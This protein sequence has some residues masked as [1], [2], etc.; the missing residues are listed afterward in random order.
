MIIKSI[1][2]HNFCDVYYNKSF[3]TFKYIGIILLFHYK[4]SIKLSFY[5]I[6]MDKCKH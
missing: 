1:L 4:D 3:L 5:T 2:L 6:H